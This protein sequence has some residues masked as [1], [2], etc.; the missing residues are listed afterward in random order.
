MRTRWR[1]RPPK[2]PPRRTTRFEPRRRVEKAPDKAR[3]AR[4]KARE[5]ATG[6]RDLDLDPE[7]RELREE[8][9]PVARA[10]IGNGIDLDL[11]PK[12]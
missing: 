2:P 9:A 5:G 1:C 6:V 10:R 12:M 3:E 8:K 7:K 11:D 4:E